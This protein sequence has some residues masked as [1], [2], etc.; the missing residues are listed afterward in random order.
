M[1]T[2]LAEE[3]VK[4]GHRVYAVV[5][6]GSLKETELRDEGGVNVLRV[7]TFDFFGVNA[8]RKG[9][10][11]SCLPFQINRAM[12]N[13]L[14]EI[15]FDLIIAILPPIT[16]LN[17]IKKYKQ[18]CHAQ[19]YL[20]LRDIFPQNAVD[21]GMIR[22]SLIIKW[23]R[24]KERAIYKIADKI[25]CM[26]QGNID[27]VLDHNPE[28]SGDKFHLLRNWLKTTDYTSVNID[29]KKKLGLEDK[30]IAL[31]GGNLGKPQ[32]VEFILA[33]AERLQLQE[34]LNI[35]FLIIG[36]GT[37]KEIIKH[38]IKEK[39]V[40]NVLLQD[41][42]PRDEYRDLVKQCHV[43]LVNLSDKFT[44][45]NIPSRTLAYF[46][47]KIPVLA[48]IDSNTDYGK[49]LDDN[50]CGL[51]SITGDIDAYIANIQKLQNDN[52]RKQL[53]ENGYNYL[54]NFCT[55]EDAYKCIVGKI[56]V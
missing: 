33:V 10:A 18:R 54:H 50:S 3:F 28:L 43:G 44:I 25:G 5:A 19:V 39:G 38:Q 37:E 22:N 6:N 14:S 52:Y 1:Y 24:H 9:V 48:A 47:A 15:K 12:D 31:Y 4:N 26:S 49:I 41:F 29:V 36:R 40:K 27:Y 35:V 8:I 11:Y 56:E 32:K 45:P 13:Y 46:E 42:L 21:L 34:N 16:F 55:V 2:D 30:F 23:F 51:W 17:I 53:G 7:K 20:I